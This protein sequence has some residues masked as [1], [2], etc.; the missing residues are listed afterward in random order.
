MTTENRAAD[1]GGRA[2]TA[3]SI[4]VVG[5]AALGATGW[6][7]YHASRSVTNLLLALL[8]GAVAALVVGSAAAIKIGHDALRNGPGGARAVV[9]ALATFVLGWAGIA[10]AAVMLTLLESSVAALGWMN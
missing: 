7:A 8:L 2:V 1:R 4:G 6:I 3:V 9:T 10:L 5:T